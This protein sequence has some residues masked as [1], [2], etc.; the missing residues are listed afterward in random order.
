MKIESI[1]QI[2]KNKTIDSL[3]LT[4]F[5]LLNIVLLI[6]IKIILSSFSPLFISLFPVFWF[7]FF[8]FAIVNLFFLSK[9]LIKIFNLS[10]LKYKYCIYSN[11]Y[12]VYNMVFSSGYLYYMDNYKYKRININDIVIINKRI[13]CSIEIHRKMG[14]ATSKFRDETALAPFRGKNEYGDIN[15]CLKI[16]DKYNKVI[17][18]KLKTYYFWNILNISFYDFI[19]D[20][21]RLY[22]NQIEIGDDEIIKVHWN[23]LRFRKQSDYNVKDY[24]IVND[25]VYDK[26]VIDL[27]EGNKNKKK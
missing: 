14:Q 16:R 10:F 20:I 27:D 8:S 4:V 13:Y 22:N 7:V 17:F 25:K 18:I 12:V 24:L 3:I 19:F 26:W 1:N 15:Y 5:L 2:I 23:G 9:N 6:N 21:F 11:N